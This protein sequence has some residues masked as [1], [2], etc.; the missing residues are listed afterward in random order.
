MRH[1]TDLLIFD[2]DGTLFDSIDWIVTCLQ[3]AA[4]QTGLREPSL[5]EARSVIG[6]SLQ[7]ALDTLYPGEDDAN[8]Q[9][10]VAEYRKIYHTRPLSSLGLY[11]GV[12]ELWPRCVRRGISWPLRREKRA[13]GWMRRLM[14]PALA[15]YLIPLAA[16]MRRHQSPIPSWWSKF[17]MNFRWPKPAP[18]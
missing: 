16:P 8:A 11:R 7:A 5:R 13:R 17:S 15:I 9:R 1:E 3:Q 12:P 10:L 4:S 2:W 18:S 14:K 6:L